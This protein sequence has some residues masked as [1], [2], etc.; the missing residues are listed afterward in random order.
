MNRIS[1]VKLTFSLLP[2][3]IEAIKAIEQAIPEHGK[4][5]EKLAAIKE[6]VTGIN[7]QAAEFWP[8]IEKTINTL[9]KLFNLTGVFKKSV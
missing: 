3:I 4:G 9:V 6:I 2:I 1:I 5:A 8:Y 7:S